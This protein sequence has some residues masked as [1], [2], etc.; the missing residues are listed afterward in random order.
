MDAKTLALVATLALAISGSM[1][2]MNSTDSVNQFESFQAKF[3]KSYASD[4][5]K[6]Y[7]FAV[8]TANM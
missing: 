3:G 5:E 8:Y 2:V 1:M 6:S 4:A 7:R